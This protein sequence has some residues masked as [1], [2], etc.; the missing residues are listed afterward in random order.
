MRRSFIL[1]IFLLILSPCLLAEQGEWAVS[2]IPAP[3]LAN[4]HAVKRYGHIEYEVI[5]YTRARYR[6]KNVITI[7]DENGDRFAPLLIIYDRLRSV[8]SIDG[9]LIDSNGIVIK[10]LKNRD[11]Q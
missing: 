7:L 11:I 3:L 2:K 4:A 10:E 9:K 8:K 5:N 6:Q 1:L